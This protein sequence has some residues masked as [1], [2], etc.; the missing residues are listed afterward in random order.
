[1]KQLFELVFEKWGS[2]PILKREI[3]N[4]IMGGGEEGFR[5][6]F[7]YL[8]WSKERSARIKLGLIIEKYV[9]RVFSRIKLVRDDNP[10]P[11]RR[12]YTWQKIEKLEEKQMGRLGRLGSFS[13]HLQLGEEEEECQEDRVGNSPQP[14]Q[15]PPAIVEDSIQVEETPQIKKPQNLKESIMKY[16]S[17]RK[18][19][20]KISDLMLELSADFDPLCD[21]IDSLKSQGEIIENPSGV[22]R[23]L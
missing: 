7:G 13:A 15:P 5:E 11:E 19:G 4:E 16:I 18:D 9:G 23:V 20:A 22:I 8:D 17:N 3:I 10:H 2:Q 21:A 14:P 12:L 6:L 1:M